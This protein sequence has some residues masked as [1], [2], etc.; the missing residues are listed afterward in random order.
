MRASIGK[1]VGVHVDER[2]ARIRSN[3]GGIRAEQSGGIDLG[4]EYI[5]GATAEACRPNPEKE[6]ER[7]SS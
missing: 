1:G 2:I 6:L 5:V 3:L 4:V 7:C